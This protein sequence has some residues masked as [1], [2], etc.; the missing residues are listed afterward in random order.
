MRPSHYVRISPLEAPNDRTSVSEQSD[1][2]ALGGRV[3][4]IRERRGWT[5]KTLAADL[6]RILR[7]RAALF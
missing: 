2:T 1:F 3:R 6:N 4:E 5:G 7:I